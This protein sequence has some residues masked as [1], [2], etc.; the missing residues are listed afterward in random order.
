MKIN[1]IRSMSDVELNNKL[2]E[3][4]TELFNLRFSQATGN[5]S[6]P[7]QLHNLKKDIARIKTILSERKA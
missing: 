1:E 4:K 2:S 3:L 7:M 5:L 6:N